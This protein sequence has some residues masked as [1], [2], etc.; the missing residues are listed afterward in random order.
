MPTIHWLGAGLSSGPGLQRLAAG[1]HPLRVWNRTLPRAQALLQGAPPTA[2]AHALD[3]D[4]LARALDPGD[5]VISMLPADWHPRIAAMAIKHRAH[6]LSSSYISDAMREFDSAA[7]TAGICLLNE[8]GLDP[9]LDHLMAHRLVQRFRDSDA[10]ES[11]SQV[12]LRSWCGGFPAQA[13]AF[14]YKFS[15]SPLGVLRAL[16][17]PA[18]SMVAGKPVDVARPWEAITDYRIPGSSG[19][20]FEAYPNRDSLPFIEDY[21]FDPTWKIHDFVRGTLRLEG[22]TEAWSDIFEQLQSLDRADAEDRLKNL[23]DR[24][25]DQYAYAE[26]EP[27]RV[28][29]CVELEAASPDGACFHEASVIDAIGRPGSSAMARLVSLPVSYA[30]DAILAGD[31]TPGVSAAPSDKALVDTWFGKLAE[32]GDVVEHRI[33]SR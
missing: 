18:R 24:L 5:L 4:D 33:L 21:R 13:N 8:V 14:R 16:G 26:D 15:W 23:S 12:S 28:V 25:W 10:C 17:T 27:D 2:T 31:I 22:W 1:Q 30:A 9:G 3:L 11:G 6:F 29:L 19:E 7:R 32:V 20:R